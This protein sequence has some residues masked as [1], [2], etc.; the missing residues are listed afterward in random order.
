MVSPDFQG[1][2]YSKQALQFGV[3]EL[4]NKGYE[5]VHICYMKG[6]TSAEK[7]YSS[8]GFEHLYTTQVYRKFAR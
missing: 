8:V 4:M 5:E 1:M 2:G 3:N 6:N 7:L